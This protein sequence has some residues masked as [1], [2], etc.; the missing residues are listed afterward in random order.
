M[1]YIYIQK[2]YIYIRTY[3]ILGPRTSYHIHTHIRTY[4]HTFIHTHIH[5]YIHTYVDSHNYSYID[6]S[7]ETL[8][9][10]RQTDRHD[11]RPDVNDEK[12]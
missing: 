12:T 4:V 10:D 1:R 6:C 8:E 9:R 3:K 2:T 7:F 5:S 11:R